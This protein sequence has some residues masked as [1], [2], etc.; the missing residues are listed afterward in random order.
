MTDDHVVKAAGSKMIMERIGSREKE[1]V[2]LSNSYHVATLDH[3]AE[4]IFERVLEFATAVASKPSA[5]PA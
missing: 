3:D 4:T 5:E 1:L 2:E